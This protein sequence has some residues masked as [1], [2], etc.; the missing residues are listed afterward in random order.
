MIFQQIPS[1]TCRNQ[2]TD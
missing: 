2:Q 1:W